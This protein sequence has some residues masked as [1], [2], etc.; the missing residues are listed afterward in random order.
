ME[1]NSKQCWECHRRRLVCDSARPQCRK[2]QTKGLDCPGYDSSKP[3]RWVP[4][5]SARSKIQ[6]P[7]AE[8]DQQIGENI[9]A[10]AV[11]PPSLKADQEMTELFEGVEYYN[12]QICSDLMANGFRGQQSPFFMP[13]EAILLCPKGPLKSLVSVALCHRLLQSPDR[14]ST[15]KAALIT[16]MHQYA[17]ESIKALAAWLAEPENHTSDATL[18]CV[19]SLMMAEI[20]YGYSSGWQQHIDGAAAMINMSGGIGSSVFARPSIRHLLRYYAIVDVFRC[21]TSPNPQL[22]ATRQQLELVNIMP[23]LYGNGLDTC[24]PCPPDLFVQVIRINHLR[25]QLGSTTTSSKADRLSATLDILRNI[26]TN[27]VDQWAAEI[28]FSSGLPLSRSG[29]SER[30][31][32]FGAWLSM[33]K[34]FRCAAAAYCISSLFP[35]AVS[36]G[37]A[38]NSDSDEQCPDDT[39]PRGAARDGLADA[40]RIFLATLLSQLRSIATVSQLRKF[41]LW[42]LVV[43]GI[44]VGSDDEMTQKFVLEELSWISRAVGIA[45]P[46][47]AREFLQRRVWPLELGERKWADLFDKPYLFAL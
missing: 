11:I 20:Q 8:K 3:V 14:P 41:V 47:V 22:D 15:D 44:H 13:L 24:V 1:R 6:P 12:L 33:A 21:T 30:K 45:A 43:M 31:P 42:P 37:G 10:R 2:C 39:G 26:K 17:G 4:M 40:R 18:A 5:Q 25:A 28:A 34:I 32:G 16:K 9:A 35:D 36:S 23:I 46:L 27:A 38:V 29:S 19:V 7:R